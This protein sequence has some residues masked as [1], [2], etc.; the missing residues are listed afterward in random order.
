MELETPRPNDGG[1]GNFRVDSFRVERGPE[2]QD[3]PAGPSGMGGG[4]D[5]VD[6]VKASLVF[7]T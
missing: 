2:S 7:L 1:G 4:K 5:G 6:R 3:A